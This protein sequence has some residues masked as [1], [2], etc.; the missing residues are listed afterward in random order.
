MTKLKLQ[1]KNHKILKPSNQKTIKSFKTIKLLS[2]I[3]LVMIILFSN[4]NISFSKK[5]SNKNYSN[6]KELTFGTQ[7]YV[8]FTEEFYQKNLKDFEKNQ[9]NNIDK[10]SNNLQ[11]FVGGN[12]G[13]NQTDKVGFKLV[14]KVF[15]DK[16]KLSNHK[17]KYDKLINIKKYNLQ[18]IERIYQ[19]EKVLERTFVAELEITANLPNYCKKLSNIYDFIEDAEPIYAYPIQKS[20]DDHLKNNHKIALTPNDPLVINQESLTQIKLLEAFDISMGNSDIVVAISDNGVNYKHPDYY[21]N[22]KINTTDPIN[23]LDDDENGYIDDF[24]G[25]N[26]NSLNTNSNFSDTYV[27]DSH[28]TNVAGIASAKTDN[29]IGIVGAGGLCSTFP[30]RTSASDLETVV[31][32]YE[33]IIYAGVRGFDVLNCSWGSTKGFSSIEQSIIEYADAN[34]VFVVAAGGNTSF[35]ELDLDK[36]ANFY[37]ANYKYVLG[38]G[39]VDRFDYQ[40]SSSRMGTQ[41]DIMAPGYENYT[42][43]I[44]NGYSRA[45]YGT[46]FS[47]PMV[48]GVV[49]V[50]KSHHTDLTN[51]QIANL[52]RITGDDITPLN[53]D[54]API[55][56]NRINVLNAIKPE[57]LNL[58]AITFDK[59]I[60]KDNNGNIQQKFY[61]FDTLN[62]SFEIRNTL[63]NGQNLTFEVY[64]VF[65]NDEEAIKII[66]NQYLL[67]NIDANETKTIDGFQFYINSFSSDKIIMRVD[68]IGDND[69]YDFFLFDFYPNDEMRT[70]ENKNLTMSISEKGLLGYVEVEKNKYGQGLFV[71]NL[72]DAMYNGG[73]ITTINNDLV[74]SSVK[75]SGTDF[76]ALKPFKNPDN[77]AI[78]TNSTSLTINKKV[79]IPQNDPFISF[80]L[81][82]NN[83]AFED[84]NEVAVGYYID[85]DLGFG[86]A[87]TQN[88]ISIIDDKMPSQYN[89]VGSI[90]YC[91]DKDS[92]IFFGALVA[93]EESNSSPQIANVSS[94][95]RTNILRALNSGTNW[96]TD[97]NGDIGGIFGIKFNGIFGKDD[98]KKCKICISGADTKDKLITNLQNCLLNIYSSNID[99][100]DYS[101]LNQNDNIIIYPNPISNENLI[102]IKEIVN[103]NNLQNNGNF[104]IQNIVEVSIYDNLG[105]II[106]KMQNSSV[107]SLDDVNISN[108]NYNIVIRFKD[109]KIITKKLIK[110]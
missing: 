97:A 77:E 38:V 10:K 11:S 64:P 22:I 63:G 82:I 27:G 53:Q 13:N 107:I 18:Q 67:D 55:L 52:I 2:M 45:G 17:E 49:G 108:G 65:Y 47:A 81:E 109:N 4:S 69:Y 32:G 98:V 25:F 90:Q 39:E 31:F 75:V 46:S 59:I 30:M 104:D 68:I 35:S 93:T 50:L 101:D 110:L 6:Q 33:S 62:L 20:E 19:T 70:F 92:K 96:Q 24:D 85:W 14:R 26:F 80:D 58:P 60:Q 102:Y 71:N 40:T 87:V 78:I 34:G 44:A 76:S 88:K 66:K 86:N 74:S 94:S 56:A 89:G 103:M 43:S 36:V 57:A 51:E 37:P 42:L 28:G 23:G 91:E 106:T 12:G 73:L 41:I 9:K 3:F 61:A 48:A 83:T 21:P 95:S 1:N 79:N 15:S 84:M 105:S 8:R 29:G 72:S 100:F 5:H 16:S 54:Y 99:D 7:F